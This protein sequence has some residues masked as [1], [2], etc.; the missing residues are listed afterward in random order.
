MYSVSV[1]KLKKEFEGKDVS[2]AIKNYY[3]KD[4]HW[5]IKGKCIIIS[6]VDATLVLQLKDGIREFSL[7]EI[8]QIRLQPKD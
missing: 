5:F 4:R 1:E 7:D 8:K 2:I 3:D 6:K